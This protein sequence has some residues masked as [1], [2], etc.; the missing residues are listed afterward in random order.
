MGDPSRLRVSDAER[1]QAAADLRDHYAAGRLSSDELSDR[2]DGVYAAQTA[3]ELDG[4]RHDLPELHPVRRSDPRRVLARRRIY[5]DAGGVVIANV[6]CVGVWVAA[7]AHGM[8]WPA[9]VMLVSV[10][11]LGRD[12]WRLFGPAGELESGAGDEVLSGQ[13]KRSALADRHE[14]HLARHEAH[15]V[16]HEAHAARHAARHAERAQRYDERHPRH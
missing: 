14:R 12:G 11:R 1:E 5:Q 9:W 15:A 10:L 13:L 6:G 2:L 3:A 7:G 16:R 4:L 8:F